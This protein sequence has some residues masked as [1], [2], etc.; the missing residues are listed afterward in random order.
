MMEMRWCSDRGLP[1]SALLEWDPEDRLRLQAFLMEEAQSCTRCG[2]ASWAW[3]MD[4]GA[5]EPAIHQCWGC[6]ALESV[7]EETRLPGSRVVLVPREVAARRRTL[8][9]GAREH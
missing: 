3:E 5:Y 2:T 1:Y 8:R 9:G 6:Y 7:E 4:R